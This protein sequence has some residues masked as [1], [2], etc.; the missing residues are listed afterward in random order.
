MYDFGG[1]NYD[2]ALG[3]WMNIDPLAELMRRHSP[4]NYAFNNP[5]Y[6]IDP[7]G[8]MAQESPSINGFAPLAD[9]GELTYAQTGELIDWKD[10]GDGTYTAES[11][12]SAATLA[13]DAGISHERANEIVQAQL[14]D[15][16]VGSDG[17]EKSNVEVGDIV[18][19]PENIPIEL[20]P[21][22]IVGFS[23]QKISTLK[24]ELNKLDSMIELN[25]EIID[26]N[27]MA[28]EISEEANL[29]QPTPG[30][31]IGG[32][33]F[34]EELN[35]ER[36]RRIIRKTEKEREKNIKKRDS[37]KNILPSKTV[38]IIFH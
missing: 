26:F 33:Y 4:Y 1:R 7:D 8:M 25:N 37:I 20:E 32:I 28:N 31:P 13:K 19:V 34:G 3:R 14:G 38:P 24:I 29:N 12:D 18:E 30:E 11:G 35:K 16:N 2:P 23:P 21:A 10:N 17:V 27:K 9:H 36:R 15:N 6:F 5:I 22:E